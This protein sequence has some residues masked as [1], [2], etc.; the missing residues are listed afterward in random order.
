MSGSQ[1]DC[2]PTSYI[3]LYTQHGII[4]DTQTEAPEVVPDYESKKD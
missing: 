4:T 2:N 1:L 3:K